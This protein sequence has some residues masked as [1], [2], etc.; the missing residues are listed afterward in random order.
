MRVTESLPVCTAQ[1]ASPVVVNPNGWWSTRTSRLT[2][3]SGVTRVT[4]PPLLLATHTSPP[5]T[6]TPNG[7]R[8]TGIGGAGAAAGGGPGPGGAGG[9]PLSP[10]TPP[11]PPAAPAAAA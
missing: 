11:P 4:L 7:R 1:T 10:S 2:L 3:P 5:A 9:A 8:P 6:A